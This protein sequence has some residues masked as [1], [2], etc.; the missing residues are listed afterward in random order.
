L[1]TL[2]P[3]FSWNPFDG[4]GSWVFDKLPNINF[5]SLIHVQ[6]HTFS[7]TT[8]SILS[9]SM[10]LVGAFLAYQL[11]EKEKWSIIKRKFNSDT[12]YYRFFYKLWHHSTMNEAITGKKIRSYSEKS[13]W[14]DF[15]FIEA[16]P[17]SIAVSNLQISK[18]AKNFDTKIIDGFVKIF[19]VL[20]VIFAFV[21]AWIDKNLVD[22]LVNTIAAVFKT[23][24]KSTKLIHKG[25]FQTLIF[26]TIL[27]LIS[28]F[29]LIYWI[30]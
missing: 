24:A 26:W 23:I 17:H 20:N 15:I 18:A 19:G 28:V 21:L 10:L 2:A 4:S 22:G 6:F 1:L 7:H 11:V 9:L 13:S 14:Y 8:V 3:V 12:I 16:I 27:L 5:L 30:N 25:S 29:G